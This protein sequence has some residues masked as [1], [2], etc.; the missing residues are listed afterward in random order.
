M[1]FDLGFHS[2]G[3]APK[4][5]LSPEEAKLISEIRGNRFKPYA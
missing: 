3:D 1:G 5:K 4:W 2:L